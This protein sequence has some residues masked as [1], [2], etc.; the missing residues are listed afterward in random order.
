[1]KPFA[2]LY[3]CLSLGSVL[4]LSQ[5]SSSRTSSGPGVAQQTGE[6]T[7]TT[8]RI[9][10][11]TVQTRTLIHHQLTNA[12]S[13][14]TYQEITVTSPRGTFKQERVIVQA[15]PYLETRNVRKDW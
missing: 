14:R 9:S 7:A 12:D 6:S 1:M 11:T 3:L 5:C 15:A 10:D 13:G 4:L 2:A 8:Q